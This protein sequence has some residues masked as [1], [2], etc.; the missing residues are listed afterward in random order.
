MSVPNPS[1]PSAAWRTIG[2]DDGAV[3]DG[4]FLSSLPADTELVTA[5]SRLWPLPPLLTPP[6]LRL[7]WPS[8]APRS[9]SPNFYG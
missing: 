2:S 5:I 6:A 4:P 3:A 8:H 7:G 9:D 1:A